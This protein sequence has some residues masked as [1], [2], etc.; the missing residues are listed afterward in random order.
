MSIVKPSLSM[1]PIEDIAAELRANKAGRNF[2][3]KED[4][5]SDVDKVGGINSDLIAVAVSVQNRTTVDNANKLAGKPAS[6]YLDKEAGD[7]I[8]G[9]AD[10][11][12]DIYASEIRDTRDEL[13]QLK[14]ELN[15]K[16]LVDERK[17]YAGYS[18]SF[19]NTNIKYDNEE[20][21]I[22]TA[23]SGNTE[24]LYLKETQNLDDFEDGKKFVIRRND[25]NTERVVTSTGASDAGKVTFT[26]SVDCLDNIEAVT[27][28]K[29]TG[30]YS[31]GAFSFSTTRENVADSM[32]EK[33]HTQTDDTNFTALKID[34]SNSGYGAYFKI[35][36]HA[37][38]AAIKL[39]VRVSKS[40]LGSA[41][42][43][44]C[45]IV[46][47]SSVGKFLNIA[48]AVEKGYI[49]ASSDV[50]TSS[51]VSAEKYEAGVD[52][53][54]PT[55][56]LGDERFFT[57]FD[58]NTNSYP[59]L[60]GGLESNCLFIIEATR[61]TGGAYW[62]LFVSC[63]EK[64]DGND[65]YQ[66]LQTN[67]KMY[68]YKALDNLGFEDDS[69]QCITN[70][71]THKEIE[72]NE[73]TFDLMFTYVSRDVIEKDEYGIAEGVYSTSIILPKPIDVSRARLSTIINREGCYYV[74]SHNNER[75]IFTLLGETVTSHNPNDSRF[76]SG[77]KIVIANQIATVRRVMGN[78]IE[79]DAPVNLDKRLLELYKT[80]IL[81]VETGE[82]NIGT[83]IPVYRIGYEIKIK[84]SFID[85]SEWD[86]EKSQFKTTELSSTPLEMELKT[87]MPL[88]KE[89]LIDTGETRKS[90]RLLFECDFSK[91]GK[92]RLANLFDL[93]IHW[94]SPFSN[95]EINAFKDIADHEAKE[96]IGRMHE[97]CM[98]FDRVY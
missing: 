48:E 69:R 35:P 6:D 88:G 51:N 42:S 78:R 83:R 11:L 31:R 96:L 56:E 24:T 89:I 44:I 76:L 82:A 7:K 55:L 66:D 22:A 68:K 81:D 91:D 86:N 67:N 65:R 73:N 62:N 46:K 61:I 59:I 74:D 25:R 3:T 43:L 77:E 85:W 2:M 23:I 70:T 29:T 38:G 37:N 63:K 95:Q 13:Y 8:I 50:I 19:K 72:Y 47:R 26:P 36:K 14:A 97:I 12:S 9:I 58:S 21:K 52:G 1:I 45:H 28:H 60:N 34:E 18:D 84:P 57:F 17:E 41:G 90:D 49:I 39:G 5:S 92:S 64:E 75:T 53:L 98:T 93:E 87:I 4:R 71:L 54:E 15:A 16:G 30:Q 33:Y 20:Y 40:K 94:K 32:A 10:Q 80:S 79:L 27:I